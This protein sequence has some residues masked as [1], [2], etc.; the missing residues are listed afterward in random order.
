MAFF[1]SVIFTLIGNSYCNVSL[2]EFVFL[3]SCL[4]SCHYMYPQR[5]EFSDRGFHRTEESGFDSVCV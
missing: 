4:A 3:L 5:W 2:I 1:S